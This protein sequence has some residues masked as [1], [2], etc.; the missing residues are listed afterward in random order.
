MNDEAG[1][2]DKA[3]PEGLCEATLASGEACRYKAKEEGGGYRLCAVHH[4]QRERLR[5]VPECAVCLSG[6]AKRGQATMAC[7]H[8]FHSKCIRAWFRQRPLTCPMCRATCLDGMALL[9]H[10]KLAPKLQALLRT[11]PPPP[12]CFFPSYIVSHLESEGMGRALGVEPH[13]VD[14]LVDIACESFTR[15]NFFAKV[16]ALGL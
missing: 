14:L 16:R 3:R 6:I 13:T 2:S 10:G 1:P 12:R 7:G 9:G 15:D 11:L 4:R 8:A 5:A